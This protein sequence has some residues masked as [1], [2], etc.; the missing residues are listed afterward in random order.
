M[1]RHS[2]SGFGF[3][4]RSPVFGDR[5]GNGF[6]S[7][8]S[9]FPAPS[10][11][12]RPFTTTTSSA[13]AATGLRGRSTFASRRGRSTHG[14]SV[15]VSRPGHL[16]REPSA[17]VWSIEEETEE[18]LMMSEM[19]GSITVGSDGAKTK[20]IKRVRFVLPGEQ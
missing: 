18:E 14:A 2:F 11:P 8:A 15:R 3:R 13:A 20:T 16:W 9:S 19:Q 12:P 6:L 10:S 17:D 4:S 1:P 7:P 5:A